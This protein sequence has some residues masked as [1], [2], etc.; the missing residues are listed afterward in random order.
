MISAAP[1]AIDP[2]SGPLPVKITP[3]YRAKV[4][5]EEKIL[6]KTGGP[7]HRVAFPPPP[8]EAS[9]PIPEYEDFLGEQDASATGSANRII[10]KYEDRILFIPTGDCISH[11]RY[12]LRQEL[13]GA[14]NAFKSETLSGALTGLR[15]YLRAHP[16]V[17]EVILSGGDPLSLGFEDFSMLLNTLRQDLE[18]PFIRIHSRALVYAPGLFMQPRLLD[19]LARS[20][21]R[22]VLHIVHP[23]ELCD[24][25]KETI[26]ALIW[27]GVRLYNQFPILRKIN[28]HPDVIRTLLEDLDVLRV[29]NLSVFAPDPVPFSS[30]YRIPIRRMLSI[31]DTVALQSPSWINA[32]RF[33]F[34]SPLGKLGRENLIG[35][36]EQNS[37]A[38]F[39]RDGRHLNYPDV[40]ED[41][42][43]PGDPGTLLWKR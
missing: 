30:P 9:R 5:E 36:D 19:L 12:C 42:D 29:R 39:M 33:V 18:I 8:I 1:E 21:V 7:L 27:A 31:M 4:V 6:G 2:I 10:Q 11:C 32:T 40:P 28:D 23:Y 43:D 24:T 15:D 34:D 13:L 37:T 22:L 38:L 35:F 20:D 3:F 25:V 17:R 26:E 41:M 14:D 16:R